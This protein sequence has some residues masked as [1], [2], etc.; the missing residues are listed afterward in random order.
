MRRKINLTIQPLWQE[1]MMRYYRG[2]KRGN[3]VPR[4][5]EAISKA[6]D[7]NFTLS[8]VINII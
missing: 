3:A 5:W 4:I 2:D 6:A 8:G 1:A 7:A